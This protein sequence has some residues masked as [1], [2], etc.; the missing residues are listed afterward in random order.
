MGSDPLCGEN[1]SSIL[2]TRLTYPKLAASL[3]T[4]NARLSVDV[5]AYFHWSNE[6]GL[7]RRLACRNRVPESLP[8][9]NKNL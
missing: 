5:Q 7:G 4:S 6:L 8:G 1:T 3:T 2:N 9:W